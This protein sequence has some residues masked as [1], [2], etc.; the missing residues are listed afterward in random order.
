MNLGC[1]S[2]AGTSDGLRPVFFNASVPSGWTFTGVLSSEQTS[3]LI[4]TS[5]MVRMAS[6]TRASTPCLAQPRILA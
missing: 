3:T 6:N 2:S 1:E 5:R 4:W